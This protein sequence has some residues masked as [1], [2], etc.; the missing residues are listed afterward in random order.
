MIVS[1]GL[2]LP[3]DFPAGFEGDGQAGTGGGADR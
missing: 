2:L 3:Q 1:G